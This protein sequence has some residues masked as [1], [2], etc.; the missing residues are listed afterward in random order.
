MVSHSLPGSP[1]NLSLEDAGVVWI[2]LPD[3]NTVAR[4]TVDSNG[5]AD[6]ESFAAPTAGSQPYD[7]IFD[8]A[9]VWFTQKAGNSLGQLN[10]ADTSAPIIEHALPTPNSAPTGLT[11]GPDGRIWVLEQA[12]NNLAV[13]DPDTSTFQEIAFPVEI[14]NSGVEKIV[15]DTDGTIWFAAPEVNLVV[16]YEPDTSSF[17]TASTISPTGNFT[18]PVG[19]TIDPNG[20]PWVTAQG[21]DAIGRYTPETL[22]FWRWFKTTHT[23]GGVTNISI[24]NNGSRWQV[25]FSETESNAVGYI[26]VRG[27]D[28][29][30]L[31]IGGSALPSATGRPW[32]IEVDDQGTVWI[33]DT[34][35]DTIV[36]WESPYVHQL[37]LPRVNR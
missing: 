33:T 18:S 19:L 11:V 9:T 25:F 5:S 22:S 12:G 34:A 31:G 8:D 28:T 15:A 36:A 20:R 37:Y 32:D 16:S 27:S 7:I 24:A 13:F 10:A 26:I 29:R 4:L 3:A 1:L 17:S 30:L 35:T 2:T 14:H 23:D 6:V 21:S